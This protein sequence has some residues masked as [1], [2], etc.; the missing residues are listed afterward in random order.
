MAL[1]VPKVEIGFDVVGAN[2]PFFRLD[3]PVKGVLDNTQYP[4]SGTIFYD[5]TDRVTSIAIRRGKNRQLDQYD[6]GLANIV[7]NNLDRTFDP[8]YALSPYAGQIIPRRAIR[9][10]SEGQFIF[11]GTIDDWNLS[12]EPS[13]YSEAA[14]ACSDSFSLLR[15]Q[16]LAAGTATPEL[17]GARIEYVLDQPSVDWPQDKRSIDPGTIQ[18]GAD[19]IAA[20]SNA[21]DYLRKVATSESGQVFVSKTGELVFRD[22]NLTSEAGYVVFADDGT[23]VGYQELKVVYGSELL[24]NEIVLT[25]FE[26]ATATA[27][28]LDSIGQYG[29]LT[30]NQTGLLVDNDSDLINLAILQ[31][32]KYSNPEYRFESVSIILDK[33]DSATQA[34]L[35]ALEIGDVVQIKFTPNGI[36]PAI[37]KF[38]EIIRIDHDITP[39]AHVVSF[40]FSSVE[41]SPWRLSDPVFGRL[42]SGNVLSF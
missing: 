28:D 12:Y 24:Y 17:P 19:V 18:L 2:A 1:P 16:T 35:L 36:P 40:G 7:F 20:E 11:T 22:R 14:A 4:L 15:N 8:E 26:D 30:L 9:I 32:R 33:F 39:E 3:D 29:V 34:E 38:N 37:E 23:G 13:G 10:S 27:S 5:V 41:N 42:S 6:A 21:L 25:N 31:A